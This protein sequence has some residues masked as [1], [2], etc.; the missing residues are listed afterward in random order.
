MTSVQKNIII[1]LFFTLM[2]S[3][4][5]RAN[6]EVSPTY[7]KMFYSTIPETWMINFNCVEKCTLRNWKLCIVG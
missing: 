6:A 5:S 2:V 4:M 1:L 3:W 7:E